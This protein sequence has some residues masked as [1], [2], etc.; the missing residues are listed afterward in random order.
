MPPC[1]YIPSLL[2]IIELVLEMLLWLDVM[3]G[4]ACYHT[5]GGAPPAWI[6]PWALVLGLWALGNKLNLTKVLDP[7]L[8]D[9][10]PL[11]SAYLLPSVFWP[12]SLL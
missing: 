6:G 8:I 11:L 10:N 9:G 4:W 1:L 3:F 2:P 5:R 12:D 7:G